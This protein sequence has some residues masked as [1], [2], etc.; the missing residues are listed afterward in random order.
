MQ[1][2]TQTPHAF[3]GLSMGVTA[4]DALGVTVAA[5]LAKIDD[6][7]WFTRLRVA[8]RTEAAAGKTAVELFEAHAAAKRE[9]AKS[10]INYSADIISKKMLA[11]SLNGTAEIEKEITRAFTEAGNDIHNFVIKHQRHLFLE[12]CKA[13]AET[14]LSVA[15]GAMGE[16]RAEA[17]RATIMAATNEQIS[18]LKNLVN[19]VIATATS[20]VEA[21]LKPFNMGQ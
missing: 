7:G 10:A 21:A 9:A 8:R 1:T 12:E 11:A 13:L 15:E 3:A 14:D 5:E 16:H 18:N 17:L 6:A 20:R 4:P 19:Q 2:K